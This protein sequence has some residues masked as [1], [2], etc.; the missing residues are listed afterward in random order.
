MSDRRDEHL[1]NL[2]RRWADG[3]RP[4]DEQLARLHEATLREL[5]SAKFLGLTAAPT[6][7]VR[8]WRGY[9]AIGAMAAA[10]LVAV[11][12]PYLRRA[13]ENRA[14]ENN[15]AGNR[16]ESPRSEGTDDAPDLSRFDVRQLADKA[17]LIKVLRETFPDD[18]VWVTETE[19]EVRIGLRSNAAPSVAGEESASG[20]LALRIVVAARKKNERIWT[21]LCSADVVTG[22]E[23]LVEVPL[24]AVPGGRL[25]VWTCLLPDGLVAVDT[26]VSLDGPRGL[27]ATP[28]LSSSLVQRE[29]V[30]CKGDYREADGWEYQV[31]QTVGRL[32]AGGA[33]P[34]LAPRLPR[35]S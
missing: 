8:R 24:E 11:L 5:E 23:E 25:A 2:L 30:P 4:S 31:F 33:A 15:F 14:P 21:T 22:P 27:H 13:P 32:P 12:V 16:A 29:G 20:E 3:R 7:H 28:S 19:G 9:C 35:R 10:V 26:D 34:P 18:L 1:D 17:A 6:A